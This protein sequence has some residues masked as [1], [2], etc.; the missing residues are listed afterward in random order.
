MANTRGSKLVEDIEIGDLL[1]SSDGSVTEVIG[2]LHKDTELLSQFVRVTFSDGK[3]LTLTPN[4]LL[5]TD[6]GDEVFAGDLRALQPVSG[7]RTVAAVERDVFRRGVYAPLTHSGRLEVNGVSCSCYAVISSH[8]AAHAVF[9]PW[10]ALYA[11]LRWIGTSASDPV[12]GY[13]GFVYRLAFD[14]IPASML[15]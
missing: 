10:R 7:G 15:L 1:T 13:A 9:L 12:P 3:S 2:W 6:R 14:F 4:H 11:A 5:F 8:R